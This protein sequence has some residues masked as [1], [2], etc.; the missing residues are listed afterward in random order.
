MAGSVDLVDVASVEPP[1]GSGARCP[2]LRSGRSYAAK[3]SVQVSRLRRGHLHDVWQYLGRIYVV[4]GPAQL[5]QVPCG[6]HYNRVQARPWAS[7]RRRPI[8]TVGSTE[9]LRAY[10][11]G[12]RYSSCTARF[13][14]R[15]DATMFR[16]AAISLLGFGL[17]ASAGQAADMSTWEAAVSANCPTRHLEWT[18]DGCW[19]DFLADFESTLPESTQSRIIELADYRRK[20]PN[21]V[22]GFSCEMSAHVDAMSKLGLLERFVVYG[23]AHYSCEE[24]AICTRSPPQKR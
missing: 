17:F 2:L 6:L 22:A 10:K 13:R 16:T 12:A 24:A 5:S 14:C 4:P 9:T 20:C 21:E 8:T 1:L 3:S 23:C 15:K 19:D 7:R 11:K 18:C